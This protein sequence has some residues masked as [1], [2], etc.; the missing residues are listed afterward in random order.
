VL[1]PLDGEGDPE[2]AESAAGKQQ[3]RRI[4]QLRHATN[5]RPPAFVSARLAGLADS[6]A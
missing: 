1:G 4:D 3:D 6:Y 2:R 5:P